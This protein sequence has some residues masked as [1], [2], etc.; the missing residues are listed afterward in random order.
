MALQFG[1]DLVDEVEIT[2]NQGLNSRPER[3]VT[4]CEFHG[5]FCSGPLARHFIGEFIRCHRV[6]DGKL[7]TK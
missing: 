4:V 6:N 2:I 7:S 1:C 3:W 5:E